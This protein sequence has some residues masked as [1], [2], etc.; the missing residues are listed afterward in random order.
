LFQKHKSQQHS[1][2]IAS[3]NQKV[4]TAGYCKVSPAQLLLL[5]TVA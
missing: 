2:L 1:Q 5:S 4:H 3:Q